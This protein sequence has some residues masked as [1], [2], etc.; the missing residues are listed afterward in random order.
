[1]T[2]AISM[3]LDSSGWNHCSFWLVLVTILHRCPKP[4]AHFGRSWLRFCTNALSNLLILVGP[5]S[6]SAW[7]SYAIC[8][9]WLLQDCQYGIQDGIQDGQHGIQDGQF[10][11]FSWPLIISP[12]ATDPGLQLSY[13][14]IQALL[15]DSHSTP[16]WPEIIV[17][18][19]WG[20]V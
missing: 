4:F 20:R 12:R 18:V 8:S 3:I 16:R 19:Y 17:L 14:W 10:C 13:G 5:G 1:M 7:M 2:Y 9:L 6:D 11:C 15:Y